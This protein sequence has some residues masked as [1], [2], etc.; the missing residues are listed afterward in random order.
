[1]VLGLIRGQS[2]D[3]IFITTY[4]VNVLYLN[5]GK[6]VFRDVSKEAGIEGGRRWHSGCAFGDFDGDGDLDLYVANYAQF[7]LAEAREMP[8][9]KNTARLG[10]TINQPGPN[11]YK[12][13]PHQFYENVGRGR[14]VDISD[15][16]G[17]SQGGKAMPY[18]LALT[19]LLHT[20]GE[21]CLSPVGLSY[22]AKLAPERYV[23]QMMGVWFLATSVGNL[24]A[25]LPRSS[26]DVEAWLASQREAGPRLPA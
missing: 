19:Y 4:G 22:V 16:V 12:T 7:D 6:G 23:S 21:L 9:Y 13:T 1:M 17:V 10:V 15:K 24:S 18:L 8:L 25:G 14:F 20:Y 2:F 5:D 26:A 11:V 3:D